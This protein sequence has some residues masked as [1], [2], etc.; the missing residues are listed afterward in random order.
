MKSEKS[1]AGY[2]KIAVQLWFP[3]VFVGIMVVWY[4]FLQS[5]GY[6]PRSAAVS[7]VMVVLSVGIVC[8]IFFVLWKESGVFTTAVLQ[9]FSA[10]AASMAA[11]LIYDFIDGTP[12]MIFGLWLCISLLGTILLAHMAKK[13]NSLHSSTL[14]EL[15]MPC[16]M[17]VGLYIYLVDIVGIV[18]LDL[19]LSQVLAYSV[20]AV[21]VCIQAAIGSMWYKNGQTNWKK[22]T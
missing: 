20:L 1:V 12:F 19:V 13:H 15:L 5:N 18:W 17:G 8:L 7:L 6:A 21:P 4:L 11:I 22:A 14:W 16:G 10:V 2:L 9:A 3:F